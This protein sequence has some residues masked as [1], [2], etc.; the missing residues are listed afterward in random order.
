MHKN[1]YEC[2]VNLNKITTKQTSNGKVVRELR[3]IPEMGKS[4]ETR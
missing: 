2:F 3:C 1:L 4:G